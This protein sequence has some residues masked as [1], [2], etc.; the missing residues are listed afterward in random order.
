MVVV[1]DTLNRVLTIIDDLEDSEE[2]LDTYFAL[3]LPSNLNRYTPETMCAVILTSDENDESLDT[4][5]VKQHNLA[6]IIDLESTQSIVLHARM[7]R[8]DIDGDGLVKA[9]NYYLDNDAYLHFD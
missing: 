3:Y 7:Q 2:Q 5:F 6:N 1:Y 9:F 8:P 4:A